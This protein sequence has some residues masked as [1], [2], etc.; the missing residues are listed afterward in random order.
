MH[1]PRL[2]QRLQAGGDVDAV[3]EDVVAVDDDVADVDA[4]AED[5]APSLRHR[6]VAAR[7][8]A[9]DRE[10]A[11]DCVDDA[12]ELDEHA[13]ARRLDDAAA[14]TGDRGVDELAAV[15]LQRRQGA[16]LVDAHQA[17]IADDVRRQNRRQPALDALPLHGFSGVWLAGA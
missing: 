7:H 5:D 9:L 17:A 6:S 12:P 2:A 11:A 1:R 14:V 3:A 4:D 13:V 15:R 10:R 8:A 16:D